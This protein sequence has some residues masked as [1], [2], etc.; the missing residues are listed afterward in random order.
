MARSYDLYVIFMVHELHF[1]LLHANDLF[2]PFAE[3]MKCLAYLLFCNS[4]RLQMFFYLTQNDSFNLGISNV[5]L[6]LPSTYFLYA[7]FGNS[8]PPTCN[9]LVH[10]FTSV[11]FDQLLLLIQL[12]ILISFCLVFRCYALIG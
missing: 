8:E 2:S 10:E 9:V 5:H 4:N 7:F 12:N 11:L 3:C 6:Q 1:V